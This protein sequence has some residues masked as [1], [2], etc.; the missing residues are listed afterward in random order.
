MTYKFPQ[1]G[2][3]TAVTSERD[4]F[5]LTAAG[6]RRTWHHQ[7]MDRRIRSFCQYFLSQNVWDE[8]Y[9]LFF[10]NEL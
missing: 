3:E 8:G 2:Q 5:Q 4:K 9:I 6:D 7:R 1:E 10:R